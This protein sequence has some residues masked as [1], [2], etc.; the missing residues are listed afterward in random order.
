MLPGL[1]ALLQALTLAVS[2]PPSSPEL[3][4]LHLAAAEGEF[5]RQG[6]AVTLTLTRGPVEAAEVLARGE[7]DLVAT[8]LAAVLHFGP[9]TARQGPRLVVGL[10]AA[11]PVVLLVSTGALAPINRVGD[12]AGRR[13]ALVAPGSAEQ[14]W[15][16]AL[17]AAT[18]TP[19]NR[20]ELLSLGP[21]G[22]ASALGRGEV[23]AALLEE[24][25]ASFLLESDRARILVDL[26]G[27]AAVARTL[28]T[29]TLHMAVFARADRCPPMPALQ[30]FA[31]AV[32]TAERRLAEA[33]VHDL[34]AR[35]PPAVAGSEEAFARRLGTARTLYL[36]GGSV[37][38]AQLRRT[39]ELLRTHRPFPATLEGPRVEDLLERMPL[40]P[41]PAAPER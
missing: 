5:A 17:L 33:P 14:A 8:S 39:L 29:P 41:V 34:A 18:R 38:R 36:P 7:A 22:A 25:Y 20:V 23:E 24:P 37:T 35:L 15:L 16:V 3:W 32:L 6:L 21:G 19:P 31:R 2:G 30:A 26:R 13:V 1:I 28:G 9:R 27:P 11:P 10:T 12:L 4:P 40:S